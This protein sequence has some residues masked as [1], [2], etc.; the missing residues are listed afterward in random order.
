[1]T[2]KAV[3]LDRDGTI[4]VHVP[5]INREE[6]FSLIEGSAEAISLFNKN[7]FK[8]IVVTNQSGIGR[9]FF[10]KEILESIHEKMY[11]NLDSKGANIDKIY[12]CPSIPEDESLMRKPRPGMINQACDEFNIISN[13][14]FMIGDRETDIEAGA[15]A[16]VKTILVLT[17][18]GL[19]EKEKISNWKYKP[20]FI[21][22]DLLSAS[23]YVIGTG[24]IVN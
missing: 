6:D 7:G 19:E 10:S 9:G 12:Y 20:D 22:K 14:S 8:V 21:A 24:Q 11:R 3:F 15:R 2:S 4:N 16:G 23:K 17:G 5:Y 18:Y 13:K 1:M